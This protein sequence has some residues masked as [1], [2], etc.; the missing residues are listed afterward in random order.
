MVQLLREWNEWLEQDVNLKGLVISSHNVLDANMSL[1]RRF[2]HVD[3]FCPVVR[4]TPFMRDPT[5]I[6]TMMLKELQHLPRGFR[7]LFAFQRD[8]SD[9]S[10]FSVSESPEPL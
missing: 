5:I 8:L 10:L 2:F 6:N 7:T 3:S 1:L 9:R 4:A